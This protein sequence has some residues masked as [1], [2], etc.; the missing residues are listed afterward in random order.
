ML[1]L[2]FDLQLW[3][4]SINLETKVRIHSLPTV[5]ERYD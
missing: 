4:S 3:A 5:R 1:V 2:K